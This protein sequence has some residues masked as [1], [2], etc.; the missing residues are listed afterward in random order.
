MKN[1][2]LNE[3][4]EEYKR[5]TLICSKVDYADKKSVQANNKAVSKMYQIVNLIK[6]GFGE[7][8][9]IKFKKLLDITENRTDLWVAVQM[10]EKFNLDKESETKALKLIREE[11]KNSMG[12]ELWLKNYLASL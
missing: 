12:M 6:I 9:V 7:E 1:F 8:G 10:L 11:A 3:L 4:I 2:T 5:N